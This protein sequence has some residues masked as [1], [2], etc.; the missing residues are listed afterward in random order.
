MCLLGG[1]FIGNDNKYGSLFLLVTVSSLKVV[2]TLAQQSI[3]H[4]MRDF[5]SVVV[6]SFIFANDTSFNSQC[7]TTDDIIIIYHKYDQQKTVPSIIHSI[8]IPASNCL[9]LI[10]H[11]H[12]LMQ[13][14]FFFSQ[15]FTWHKL[16]LKLG[17]FY[18]KVAGQGGKGLLQI[19]Q[20]CPMTFQG[21][22]IK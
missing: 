14:I 9:I 19:H 5:E 16:G 10:Y 1:N 11:G 21:Y 22:G 3:M 15:A 8:N 6:R 4:H 20:W 18:L 12:H 17:I 7:P 2:I 13:C